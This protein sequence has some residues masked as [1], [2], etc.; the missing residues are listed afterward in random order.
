MK[1]FFGYAL[2]A[3]CS[4]VF[5]LAVLFPAEQVGKLAE[6]RLSNALKMDISM[7]RIAPAGLFKIRMDNPGLRDKDGFLVRAQKVVFSSGPLSLIRK[8][9]KV[10]LEA[11][12]YGGD[13]DGNFNASENAKGFAGPYDGL[14]TFR[15]IQVED[16]EIASR[17]PE[18][19]IVTGLLSGEFSFS[20]L[21]QKWM[22]MEGEGE[23]TL[24]SG[25]LV[26][27]SGIVAGMTVPYDEMHMLLSMKNGKIDIKECVIKGDLVRGRFSGS[28]RMGKNISQSRVNI[29]GS[30]EPTRS[31]YESDMG[32]LAKTVFRN[33]QPGDPIPFTVSGTLDDIQFVPR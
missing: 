11:Q 12:V 2:Y 7:S 30:M 31:F 14:V 23:F 1:K 18:P 6:M 20:N 25:S 16:M 33:K 17:I 28:V 26:M 19:G 27:W 32:K 4:L 8:K 3:L 15:N 9:P 24:S 13:V 5:F 10:D 29:K 22:S 21:S